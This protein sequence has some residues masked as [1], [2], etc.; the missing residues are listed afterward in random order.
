MEHKADAGSPRNRRSRLAKNA[1]F[2]LPVDLLREVDEA[3]ARGAAENKTVFVERALRQEIARFRRVQRRARLE[4]ARRDPLFMRD[5]AEVEQ[6]FARVDAE[7]AGE[8]I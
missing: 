5:V 7:S 6:D 4:E 3:V 1:T 2:A 8:I